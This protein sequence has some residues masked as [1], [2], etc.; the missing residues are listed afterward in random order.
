MGGG[1]GLA[2]TMMQGMAFG[3]GS[4]VAH[5]VIGG[6]AN[7][8]TGGGEG[9]AAPE[10]V[11]AGAGSAEAPAVPVPSG[12]DCS[13]HQ[14]DFFSCLEKSSND[15]GFCQIQFDGLQDCLAPK[16]Y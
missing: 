5:R 15:I 13:G 9:G 6:V 3:A 8:M 14:Q 16:T 7:S 2:S 10:A 1:G 4:A 12:P 11:A